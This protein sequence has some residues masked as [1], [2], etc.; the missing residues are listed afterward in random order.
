MTNPADLAAATAV[1]ATPTQT[2]HDLSSATATEP[3]GAPLHHQ[4][5]AA[6]LDAHPAEAKP[7]N[8]VS[9]H[10]HTA[11]AERVALLPWGEGSA[12]SLPSVDEGF[13]A[14]STLQGGATLGLLA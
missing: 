8:A 3:K 6:E 7:P 14:V 4:R 2:V 11:T 5:D 1:S 12:P 9:E 10:G 13:N